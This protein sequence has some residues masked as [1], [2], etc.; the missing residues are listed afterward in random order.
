MKPEMKYLNEFHKQDTEKCL[1]KM[2]EWIKNS[3]TVNVEE[4]VKRHRDMHKKL[5]ELY[6]D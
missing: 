3:D 1:K 6:P 2:A 4:E 5:K